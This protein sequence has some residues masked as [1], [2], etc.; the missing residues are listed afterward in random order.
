MERTERAYL[1]HCPA[2]GVANRV[3]ADS[4]GKRGK[5]GS[6]RTPLPPLF[7]RPVALTDQ[8]FDA[9]IGG[10]PGPVLAE[11]WAGW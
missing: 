4:E 8:N 1:I 10:Y 6:C 11:F 3:P 9:F 2:C 7:T 5:C